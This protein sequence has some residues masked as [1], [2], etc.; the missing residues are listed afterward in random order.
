MRPTAFLDRDGTLNREVDFV[1][2]P[3]ELVV[4][5]GARD[6]LQ[7][8]RDAGWRIVVVTNQSGVARGYFDER[9][10]AAIHAKLHRELGALPDAYLHCPH[11]PDGGFGYA[12][13][14]ACRKPGAGLLHEAKELLGADLSCGAVVGDS[15]RD[16]LMARDTRLCT[17]LV[18]SGKPIAEQQAKLAAAGATPDFVADALPDAVDWLLAR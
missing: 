7:R 10:L 11:H 12:R 13:A 14:C 3:D 1:R 15:A 6:A 17:V 16:V 4:L 18:R 9:T 5:P 8:L 2:S